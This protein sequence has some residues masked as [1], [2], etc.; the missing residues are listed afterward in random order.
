[1]IRASL[2][3]ALCLALAGCSSHSR[4]TLLDLSLV[5]SDDQNPDVNDRPSPMIVKLVELNASSAF[6]NG[7]FFALYDAADDTL[8]TDLV[9]QE[10]LAVR[11][12][13]TVQLYL[14]L[15]PDSS[16]V[17]VVAAYRELDGDNW[18]Y[19]L[20][21]TPGRHN[22]IELGL[23]RDQLVRIQPGDKE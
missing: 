10:S 19:L 18:R 2:F 20:P 7:D 21:L 6:A 15:N 12:G 9:A 11:P 5:A 3:L 4:D 17:G 23:T 14:R 8:G 16:Y 1:M 22:K 13:E